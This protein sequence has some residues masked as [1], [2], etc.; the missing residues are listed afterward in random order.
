MVPRVIELA[1]TDM[2]SLEQAQAWVEPASQRQQQA[3]NQLSA[4]Q[5]QEHWQRM[6]QKQQGAQVLY[7]VCIPQLD[8]VAHD[9]LDP[10]KRY[11]DG[12]WVESDPGTGTGMLFNVTGD[13]SSKTFL[14]SCM[15]GSLREKHI[16]KL[17]D[18][19]SS[20]TGRRSHVDSDRA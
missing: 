11:H 17:K 6:A 20:S 13:T 2:P 14:S 5:K 9:P 7:R 18:G 4:Q 10:G 12:I 8:T 3:Y 15:T 19:Y 16:I 1:L